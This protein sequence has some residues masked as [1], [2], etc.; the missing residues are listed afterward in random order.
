MARAMFALGSIAGACVVQLLI[1]AAWFVELPT[2]DGGMQAL[3]PGMFWLA[4]TAILVLSVPLW[5]ELVYE[6]WRGF[7]PLVLRN[8]LL[9]PWILGLG[10]AGMLAGSLFLLCWSF[11]VG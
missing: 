1:S 5:M 8:L 3:L 6:P 9:A 4:G 10:I 7:R 2:A 11:F